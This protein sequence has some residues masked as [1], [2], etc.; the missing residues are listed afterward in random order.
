MSFVSTTS[1]ASQRES[2]EPDRIAFLYIRAAK[3]QC[4]IYRRA[5][6]RVRN[7]PRQ[8]RQHNHQVSHIFLLTE[9]RDNASDSNDVLSHSEWEGHGFQLLAC[10]ERAQRAEGCQYNATKNGA[11]A[12][13]GPTPLRSEISSPR[14]NSP[15]AT[16][17]PPLPHKNDR[18]RSQRWRTPSC[19]N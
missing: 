13:E 5:V 16:D 12:A 3:Q 2:R 6:P 9:A 15:A 18:L 1:L 4:T 19:G 7:E 14:E 11:L 8:R 17:I 10:P